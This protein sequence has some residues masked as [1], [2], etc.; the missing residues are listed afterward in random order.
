MKDNRNPTSLTTFELLGKL[1]SQLTMTQLSYDT[2]IIGADQNG[3]IA[4]ARLAAAGQ[5]VLVLEERDQIG[6][7]C[8]DS[9]VWDGYRVPASLPDVSLLRQDLVDALGLAD[10][11]V[12]LLESPVSAFAPQPNG[13][14]LA[15]WRDLDRTVAAIAHHSAADARAYPAFV[16]EIQQLRARLEPYLRTTHD[17]ASLGALF[18]NEPELVRLATL[19]LYEYLNHWFENDLLKGLIGSLGVNNIMRGPR[20]QGTIFHLLNHLPDEK[21]VPSPRGGLG[22]GH[23]VRGGLGQLTAALA[24]VAQ[25]NG[26]EIRTS[27]GVHHLLLEDGRATGVQ[28]A[29]GATQPATRV[30]SSLDARRTFFDLVG[31]PNLPPSIVRQV[32]S[33]KYRG[34]TAQINLALSGLPAFSGVDDPQLLGGH[35]V[36]APDLNYLERAYDAAK[37]GDFSPQPYLDM[38]IPTVL[39]PSLAPAGKHLLTIAMQYAPYDL[40]G[41]AWDDLREPL[42]DAVIAA[43]ARYAPGIE[44]LIEARQ[45]ITP[46]DYERDY[47][48]TEGNLHQGEMSVEQMFALRPLPGWSDYCTPIENL[49]LCGAAAHPGGGITGL[50]GWLA[51]TALLA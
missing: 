23:F 51:A 12:T 47:G 41:K 29:N 35:I 14:G 31:A 45:V 4:A 46:M 38:V 30:L 10:Q 17:A 16:A 26:A 8:S 2:I 39:D 25:K 36:I 21:T 32:R 19:P 3:L 13:S 24:Q 49:W 18:V 5:Q 20:A 7:I 22:W 40:R 50:P 1:D 33:I 11:G 6:G 48:L 43:V 28:L 44:K 34:C 15:L 42:A 27:T 9:A 37:Y